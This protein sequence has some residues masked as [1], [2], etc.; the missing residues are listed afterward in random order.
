VQI[1]RVTS[2]A[3]IR[4]LI[5]DR[6]KALHGKD[7]NALLSNYTSGNRSGAPCHTHSLS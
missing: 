7:I 4:K 6:L 1:K 5:D 3:A 2:K